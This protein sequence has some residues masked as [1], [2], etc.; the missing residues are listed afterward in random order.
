MSL[1]EQL[2][3]RLNVCMMEKLVILL[4]GGILLSA[5]HYWLS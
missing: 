1:K 4:I 2:I 5:I 3:S